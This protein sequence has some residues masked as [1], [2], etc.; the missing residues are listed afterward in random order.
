MSEH[1]FDLFMITSSSVFVSV[2]LHFLSG[3][4]YGPHRRG[5]FLLLHSGHT[6]ANVEDSVCTN[7][8]NPV[9]RQR[10]RRRAM[11]H[12]ALCLLCTWMSAH[13]PTVDKHILADR[14]E[15]SDM[16]SSFVC[17]EL[18]ALIISPIPEAYTREIN[19]FVRCHSDGSL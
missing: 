5:C 9:R 8:S 3:G 6:Q 1:V 18:W 14:K 17:P 4:C 10:R 15:I 16:F 13:K 7:T 19:D 2:S 12:N 11:Q